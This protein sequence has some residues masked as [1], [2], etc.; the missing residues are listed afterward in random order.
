MKKTVFKV[1]SIIMALCVFLGAMPV[2]AFAESEDTLYYSEEV[3]MIDFSPKVETN[4]D[5]IVPVN[6]Y[7]STDAQIDT[8]KFFYNQL[9]A[10]Q[11]SIY[12]QLWLA[13]MNSYGNCTVSDN[14]ITIPVNM[15][16]VS[17]SGAGASSAAAK[18]NAAS[19]AQQYIM[20]VMTALGEDQ[21]TYFGAK[22]V[23][24]SYAI[25]TPKYSNGQY[26]C[27][28]TVLNIVLPIDT[29]HYSSVEDITAKRDAVL[30]EMASIKV[31]GISRHE[32]LKSIHDYL[33]NNIVYDQDI[34]SPNIY[35]VYGA[36][37][38]G[39]CVCEGYAEAFK[40]LCD[41]EEIPCITVIG[42]GAGGAHK[43]NMVLMEDNEWYTLDT[44][45]DDQTESNSAV[46]FY[47]Y[48]LNGSGTKTPF[49]YPSYTDS[50]VHI[51]DCR[52]FSNMTTALS[53]PTL[54]TDTYG[55]G[56]LALDAGDVHFDKARGVI[57]VGKDLPYDYYYDIFDAVLYNS[58]TSFRRTVNGT[59]TTT[60]TLTVTDGTTT[61]TYLVAMRGDIDASNATNAT[62]YNKITQ[63]CATTHKVDGATAKFYAGDMNQDGAIDGFD[64]IAHELYTS[65]TL[66]FD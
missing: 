15:T 62:D 43:W 60:S 31:N 24:F 56:M 40:M 52:R 28:I 45:W 2:M 20:L 32:K 12:D 46:E 27:S 53:Y 48:F 50:Q 37:V 6:R 63:T 11:K 47:D 26:T 3:E 65:G 36:F 4:F 55:M 29:E 34:S 61:K 21:P 19:T 66:V 9:T 38:N 42:T 7:Y 13:H 10:T 51:G 41:R 39:F 14:E 8:T 49:F 30:I 59:G 33:A 22:G 44:T 5:I 1:L 18:N 57:M 54:S 58:S 17:I 25:S 23:G 64:A 16:G 35:D